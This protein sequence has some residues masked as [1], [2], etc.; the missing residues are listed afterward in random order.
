MQALLQDETIDQEGLEQL[1]GPR[2]GGSPAEPP[3]GR[4]D[5]RL[6][7]EPAHDPPL[8]QPTPVHGLNAAETTPGDS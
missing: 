2:P 8:G 3:A 4:D 6:A 1:L 7:P 5:G